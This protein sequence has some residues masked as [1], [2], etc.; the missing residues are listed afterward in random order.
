[1]LL[2]ACHDVDIPALTDILTC[3]VHGDCLGIQCCVNLNLKV[4]E[5]KM[6]A[7]LIINPCDFKFSV[8]FEKLDLNFTLFTYEWGKK[9]RIHVSDDLTL[10]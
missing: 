6:K 7:W 10:M 1:M 9:E 2:V 3:S 8:G 5:L 4:T